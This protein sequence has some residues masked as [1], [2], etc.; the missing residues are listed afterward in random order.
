VKSDRKKIKA[1][2]GNFN[3]S[4]DIFVYYKQ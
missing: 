3:I 1:I 4:G 2:Q